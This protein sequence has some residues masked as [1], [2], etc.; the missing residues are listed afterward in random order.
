[1]DPWLLRL[2]KL[3][4]STPDYK[5]IIC[6]CPRVLRVYGVLGFTELT[7]HY[8]SYSPSTCW[9]HPITTESEYCQQNQ[10]TTP[11]PLMLSD[12]CAGLQ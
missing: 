6:H 2:L 12:N 3:E 9:F 7:G 10:S 8:T 4:K 1:M 5:T 11:L